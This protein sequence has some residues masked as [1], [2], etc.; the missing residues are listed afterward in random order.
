MFSRIAVLALGIASSVAGSVINSENGNM[1]AD[2]DVARNLMHHAR[3]VQ[4]D[5]EG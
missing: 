4:E 1:P 3:R 2:S 5:G